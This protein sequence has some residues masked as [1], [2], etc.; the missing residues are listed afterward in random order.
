VYTN[1]VINQSA[2]ATNAVHPLAKTSRWSSTVAKHRI[3]VT[4]SNYYYCQFL[5]NRTIFR[6]RLW[7]RPVPPKVIQISTFAN[8]R[9]CIFYRPAAL[10]V[11]QPTLSK[12]RR[13]TNK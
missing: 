10:L 7:V 3:S 11:T 8:C 13:K 12:H 9:R 2:V 1:N 6:R 4:Y 5:S